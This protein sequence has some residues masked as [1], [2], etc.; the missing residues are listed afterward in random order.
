M[1]APVRGREGP[2]AG[3]AGLDLLSL[4]R[5]ARDAQGA[6]LRLRVGAETADAAELC[7]QVEAQAGGWLAAGLRA[8][9]RVAILLPRSL[10]EATVLLA[11]AAAGGI[12]VPVHGKLKDAQIAHV[13]ADCEPFAVVTSAARTVALADPAALLAGRRVFRCGDAAAAGSGEALPAAAGAGLP[14]PSCDAAAV[15]LYTSGSTGLAKGIVQSHRNLVLGAAIV[16]G[17]LGLSGQDHLLALLPFSFDYGLNQLLSALYAGCRVTAADHLGVGELAALLRAH[18]PSGLAG[19]PSLWHEVAAGLRSGA[20]TAAD[21]ASLRYVTNSGGALRT[22]DAS[23]L[24]AHWP[25]V[26]VFAMYGLT[27]AFRSAYLPPREFDAHPDSFGRALPG[28]DLLLVD[29]TSGAVLAGEATGELV[30]AGALVAQGYW[31]RPA[32]TAERFRPDPR[33]GGGTVVFSGDI[34]RRDA[35]GRL[36]FVARRDRLLKVAGHRVSPDE[37]AAAVAG[38]PGVG[39]VAVFGEPGGADGHR[40]VLCVSG[41]ATDGELLERVRRRCRAQLPSYMVPAAVHVLPA[42]PHNP[43]GKVDEAALRARVAACTDN[44]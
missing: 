35:D 39:E 3:E 21:G 4:V 12:A 24:R 17:Y 34:V 7:A 33:G 1:T 8:G 36:Y 14:V 27:E 2:L 20:L 19:V 18:R 28:V 26:Q 42:L 40:I 10:A 37:V 30:H 23:T 41:D 6:A 31:R 11:V 43:N 25:H 9:D 29:P 22:A 13:L 15:L 5:S 38:L 16:A 32:D 44:R